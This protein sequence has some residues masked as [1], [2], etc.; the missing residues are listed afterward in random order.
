MIFIR[1]F[2]LCLEPL[3]KFCDL[4][5]KEFIFHNQ[6]AELGVLRRDLFELLLPLSQGCSELLIFTSHGLQFS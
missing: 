3:L 5:F 2:G 6:L 4:G 1:Y